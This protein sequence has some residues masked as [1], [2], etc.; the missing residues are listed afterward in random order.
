MK[1][2]QSL[3]VHV[4]TLRITEG[5]STQH[6]YVTCSDCQTDSLSTN[7]FQHDLF[8]DYVTK[9]RHTPLHPMKPTLP[10]KR[11]THP[12]QHSSHKER[13]QCFQNAESPQLCF[14][15]GAT[16]MREGEPSGY[17]GTCLH[18]TKPK[19]NKPTQGDSPMHHAQCEP[20]SWDPCMNA[21]QARG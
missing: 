7:G 16:G 5:T 15:A 3:L 14:R 20:G 21:V 8:S 12:L 18:V 1:H 9:F 17:K 13:A 11:P 10:S 4:R 6:C 19:I 2:N